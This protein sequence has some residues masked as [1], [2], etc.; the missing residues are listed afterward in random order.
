MR[1]V[2]V[3]KSDCELR[4]CRLPIKWVQLPL[5]LALGWRAPKR[6]VLGFYFAG[7]IERVGSGVTRFAPGQAV[8]GCTGFAMGAYAD[9]LTLPEQAALALKPDAVS[10][11]AAAATPLGGLNALHFLKRADIRPGQSVV[12]N[13]AGGSIG[14]CA[15]Q[16]A[17][18][19][20]ADV[21]AVDAG[22]KQALVHRAGADR[23]IDYRHQDF[24]RPPG[25][26]DVVF[27]VVATSDYGS[28]LRALKPGGVYLT[29]NPTLSKMLRSVWTT[30]MTGKSAHF[31]FAPE[32]SAALD[33]LAL[34]LADGRIRP[35]IDRTLA[36]PELV[37]AHHAVEQETRQG[38]L[39]LVPGDA[40][41]HQASGQ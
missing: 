40:P 33:E 14:L 38:S 4:R 20:G 28:C 1:A 2:E 41:P 5:R 10:F 35:I 15:I 22:H 21:T 13:G 6:T 12:V 32:T 27:D 29:A 31:A 17:K 9:C 7:E 19:L 36:F 26:Y 37:E 39:I 18:A 3:T 34:W 25:Q 23:F 8:F 30:R 11:E 16:I 24:T